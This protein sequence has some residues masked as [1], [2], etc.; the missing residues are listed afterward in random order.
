MLAAG[1]HQPIGGQ[2][3]SPIAQPHHVPALAPLAFIEHG[4]E[5]ELTP[6]RMRGQHR[7]PIP[8]AD[9]THILAFDRIIT[10]L[11]AMQETPQLR[12]IEMRREQILATEI[13]NRAVL[14][15]AGPVAIG[16]DD[17]YV[18]ALEAVADGCP[19]N[20][21]EHGGAAPNQGTCPFKDERNDGHSQ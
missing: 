1:A 7:A 16:F 8:C 3:E 19:H 20:P 18:F 17:A 6:H 9:R 21:Q 12:Q 5:A 14:G 10:S 13:E 11:L 4:I 2:H 15:F